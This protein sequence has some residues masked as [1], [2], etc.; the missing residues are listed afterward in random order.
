MP[1]EPYAHSKGTD[2]ADWQLLSEHL[3]NVSEL[4]S[5]FAMA[6]DSGE[7]GRLVG[8]LHDLGKARSSFQSYLRR[9]NGIDEDSPDYSEHTHSITGACQVIQHYNGIGNL[10]AYCIAGHHAGLADW[11]GGAHPEG[12]LFNRLIEGKETTEETPVQE[13]LRQHTLSWPDIRQLV[14]Y[15]FCSTDS[16]ASF[17]IR[18]LFSCLTDADFLDTERFINPEQYQERHQGSSLRELETRFFKALDSKQ[19][20]APPSTVNSIRREIREACE[21]AAERPQGMFS[22]SVPTG[23]GKTLSS[24][25]FALRH[26][27]RHGAE[28]II[29][30]IPY[31]SIIEQTSAILRS[32]LGEENVIEHHAN[33][34]PERETMQSRL[35]SENWDAPIIVTTSVQFF[36]SLYASKASRCRKL[37]H[38]AKSVVIIDEVQ[39]LPTHLLLPCAEALQQLTKHF[40]TSI[41]LS[42]ATQLDLPGIDRI[43]IHEIISPNLR[44]YERLRRTNI[45][46]PVNLDVRKSWEEVAI[47]LSQYRQ[48][49][50]IVNTRRDCR[51]LFA[52][53]PEGTLHLSASMCGEHRSHIIDEIRQRLQSGDPLRVISTQL[54]EAGVDIDFPVV[55]RAFTGLP[56]I[57]QAAGRCNREGNL[58]TLGRVV[59]FM[60]PHQAPLGELRK[61][62]NVMSRMLT[63][64][65]YK[66]NVEDP[67]C[68]RSY[69][70]QLHLAMNNLGLAFMSW[71]GVPVPEDMR[72]GNN[73][74][75]PEPGKYQF[76]EAE[77]HFKVIDDKGSIPILVRYGQGDELI[78]I[79]QKQG[80]NRFLLRRLQRFTVTISKGALIPLVNEGVVEELIV[81]HLGKIQGLYIQTVLKSAYNNI[82]GLNMLGDVIQ[83]E[84][85]VI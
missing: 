18:M 25:A 77:E 82:F 71:L 81:P 28:R 49:L 24:M 4:S 64:S 67:T 85:C 79:L 57:V 72:D 33:L 63:S 22:L 78:N 70:K 69:F 48:V 2:T 55:Y 38:I 16:S 76:R 47:E 30:V 60:P 37:H 17:W 44:L 62:E 34:D 66:F 50:C 39:L 45:E 1:E 80:P 68:F 6:F 42:T 59:V 40:H 43:A 5:A 73:R 36:E 74:S 8:W 32:I 11:S 75:F 3:R 52:A 12:S 53:M 26:A 41:V 51:E 61:M 19:A 83:P 14:P 7:A 58:K 65:S 54:V 27:M 35:A 10:F 15:R 23:G 21:I 29:V 13:W 9:C 20:S 46:F 84:D 56:S 31:T